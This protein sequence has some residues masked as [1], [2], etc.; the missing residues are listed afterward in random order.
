MDRL[1][2]LTDE[3]L[4]TLKLKSPE[5]LE[6]YEKLHIGE[7]IKRLRRKTGTKQLELARKLKTSQSVIARIENGKQNLTLKTLTLI[8]RAFGK[9]L[10][11][12]FY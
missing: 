4:L 5:A 10:L 3:I 2:K 11:M 8:A 7:Q 6:K 9:K 12:K 1:Q